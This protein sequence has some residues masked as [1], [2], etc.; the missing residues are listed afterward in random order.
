MSRG[1]EVVS[2]GGKLGEWKRGVVGGGEDSRGSE[3]RGVGGKEG[4]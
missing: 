4:T 3:Q 2:G 1:V